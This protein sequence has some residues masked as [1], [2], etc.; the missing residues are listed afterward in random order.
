MQISTINIAYQVSGKIHFDYF[1][2]V[3]KKGYNIM[4]WEIKN[5]FSAIMTYL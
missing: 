1:F 5:P 2:K 4:T 3:I